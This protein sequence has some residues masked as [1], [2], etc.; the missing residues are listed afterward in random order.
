MLTEEKIMDLTFE[1]A[2][3]D[4]LMLLEKE[5]SLTRKVGVPLALLGAGV[6]GGPLVR[7]GVESTRNVARQAIKGSADVQQLSKEL[8]DLRAK[9]GTTLA[10][11]QAL[12]G[13]ES[14]LRSMLEAAKKEYGS[15]VQASQRPAEPTGP[16]MSVREAL[17][18]RKGK[19]SGEDYKL[20]TDRR[21]TT[22]APK[23]AAKP[24]LPAVKEKVE[25]AAK[26]PEG[27]KAAAPAGAAEEKPDA[28]PWWKRK[29][30][31]RS[32]TPVGKPVDID[33]VF[34]AHKAGRAVAEGL[35]GLVRRAAE[36]K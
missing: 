32:K 23:A 14:N 3:F 31:P 12:K 33:K 19:P 34:A 13:R 4:E 21:G 20:S 35:P 36:G 7:S 18:P 15:S 24:G 8:A 1:Q 2:F 26:K 25:A 6:L 22:S 17:A 29:I 10:E 27:P 30:N 28:P 11:H 5:A 16:A 9:H